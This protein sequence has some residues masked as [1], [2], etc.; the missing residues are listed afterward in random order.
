MSEDQLLPFIDNESLYSHARKLVEA[1]QNAT[2]R[3]DRNLHRNVV[4]PFSALVDAIRQGVTL[5][6]WFDQERSRQIQKSLQN[7]IGTFHQDVIGSIYEWENTGSGG[8]YDA[9]CESKRIIAEIKNK[10]NTMNS[11]SQLAVYDKLSKHLDYGDRGFKA[12]LVEIVPK[13]PEPYEIPFHPTERGTSRPVRNDILRID[14]KSFYAIATGDPHALK[15][16]YDVMPLVLAELFGREVAN[17]D[18][19]EFSGLF[20]RVYG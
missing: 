18:T 8:S 11:G 20:S 10:Y 5:S 16:L 7:A 14:G 1:V 15:K 17:I 19:R 3:A 9:R 2:D 12:Y 4:D 13:S 6:E